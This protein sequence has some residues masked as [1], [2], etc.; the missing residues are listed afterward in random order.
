MRP[1]QKKTGSEQGSKSRDKSESES[2]KEE[3][4]A[5][6]G[7]TK[8]DD[9]ESPKAT[10]DKRESSTRDQSKQASKKSPS[11]KPTDVKKEKTSDK[12]Q[13]AKT[14]KSHSTAGEAKDRKTA[15]DRDQNRR[16]W[17]NARDNRG[18]SGLQNRFRGDRN[19]MRTGAGFGY[20]NRTDGRRIRPM[21]QGAGEVDINPGAAKE[22]ILLQSQL[23]MAIKNQLSMLSQTQ[24]ALEQAKMEAVGFSMSREA[25]QAPASLLDQRV[26]DPYSYNQLPAD[27]RR[28]QIK[29]GNRRQQ[30]RN[31]GRP[32]RDKR[33]GE[34][35]ASLT[36]D[37]GYKRNAQ[38]AGL[39][40]DYG[41]SQFGKRRSAGMGGHS[42]GPSWAEEQ[43]AFGHAQ[44]PHFGYEHEA[45]EREAEYRSLQSG[46]LSHSSMNYGY[47]Y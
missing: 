33:D 36:G 12:D 42:E 19:R 41:S 23:S 34:Q 15:T 14:N 43:L 32:A 37:Y 38:M 6:S 5:K 1:L 46:N 11:S 7:D 31:R 22:M 2:T 28:G 24:V 40:S 17:R 29:T 30:Q 16:R 35:L 10:S 26:S 3:T 18:E 47:R 44:T 13:V 45:D 27:A 21:M 4:S 8:K 25:A 39:H 9:K 20:R